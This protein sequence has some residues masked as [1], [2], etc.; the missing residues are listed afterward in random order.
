MALRCE[1][2]QIT[3]QLPLFPNQRQR[4][5][6]ALR[7]R[8]DADDA[9]Q[10]VTLAMQAWLPLFPGK[11]GLPRVTPPVHVQPSIVELIASA[12]DELATP[13]PVKFAV[14][15][16]D[17]VVEP[18]RTDVDR[19][20]WPS[21]SQ[22]RRARRDPLCPLPPLAAFPVSVGS[23]IPMEGTRV[24]EPRPPAFEPP[25]FDLGL[26]QLPSLDDLKLSAAGFIWGLGAV[27]A[28]G[29][30]LYIVGKARRRR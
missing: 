2:P 19:M 8:A 26:P 12:P 4:W 20:P 9:E 28:L 16:F 15:S 1:V 25:D 18:N 13:D 27:V 5:V 24:L 23:P 10:L 11:V 30:A 14:A 7:L 22:Q 3:A 6:F 17:Y 29:G 21:F